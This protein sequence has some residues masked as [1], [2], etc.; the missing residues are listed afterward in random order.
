MFTSNPQWLE[1][2]I[3]RINHDGPKDVRAIEAPLSYLTLAEEI[4]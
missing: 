3:S 2:P 1:V 4:S